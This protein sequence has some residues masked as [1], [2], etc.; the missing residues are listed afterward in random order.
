MQL[1]LSLGNATDGTACTPLSLRALA[2]RL[3]GT[4]VRVTKPKLE[5]IALLRSYAENLPCHQPDTNN[6]G[7][8]KWENNK[9]W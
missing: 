1:H 8:F 4:E 6:K 5:R 3:L 9:I 2:T 7:Q